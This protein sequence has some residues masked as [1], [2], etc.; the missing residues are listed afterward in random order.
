MVNPSPISSPQGGCGVGVGQGGGVGVG[1]GIHGANVSALAR[2]APPL[3]PPAAMITLLP[4]MNAP[5]TN[6][7]AVFKFAEVVHWSRD[8]SYTKV[9]PVVRGIKALSLAAPRP[10][11]IGNAVL[12]KSDAILFEAPAVS[13]LPDDTLLVPEV[14]LL[15][16][17]GALVAE[18]PMVTKGLPPPNAN[19]ALSATALPGTFG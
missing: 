7:R 8:G 12:V 1:V 2:E 13:S 11:A 9:R 14:G 19:S 16:A 4:E 3:S 5:D 17:E 10:R 6:E 15:E 18:L